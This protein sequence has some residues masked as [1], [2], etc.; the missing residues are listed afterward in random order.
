M[1]PPRIR[2]DALSSAGRAAHDAALGAMLGGNLF[3]RVAMHP[4]LSDVG[5][6]SE[7]GRVVN[8]AWTRYGVVNSVALGT[9][10]ASWVGAR[11]NEARP[12][13]LSA[14]E[15]R[16]ALAK[17]AALAAVVVTGGAAAV[18]GIRFSHSSPAGAVPLADGSH[19]TPDTPPDA[20]RLKRRLNVLGSAAIASELALVAA[21]AA[22]GQANFRRPP[23]RRVARRRY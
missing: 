10:V 17:D 2:S 5:D 16:L 23:L 13:W 7:R 4:A 19:P 18:E 9:L 3:G 20:A 11:A 1:V 15:R 12:R 21:N 6:P 14:R 22:L 8:R